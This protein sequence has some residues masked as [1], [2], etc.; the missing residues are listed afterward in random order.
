MLVS[1]R[2]THQADTNTPDTFQQGQTQQPQRGT[3][4]NLPTQV[5]AA[6]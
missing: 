6:P 4:K 1:S 3:N 5:I 2:D